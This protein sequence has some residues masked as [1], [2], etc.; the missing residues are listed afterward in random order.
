MIIIVSR[1][2][3]HCNRLF[4]SIHFHAY[5]IEAEH[6]FWNPTLIG[7]L[8]GASGYSE[9]LGDILQNYLLP[10]VLRL[11]KSWLPVY[12]DV[13]V[14]NESAITL[15]GGWGFRRHELTAKHRGFLSAFYKIRKPIPAF[16]RELFSLLAEAR[17][18]GKVIIGVHVR[19]GDYRQ[20]EGGRYW[21]ADDIYADWIKAARE[22]YR[23]HCNREIFVIVCSN[24]K[25][26]PACGQDLTSASP[27]HV[28]LRIFQAC[29]LL[30]GPPS[31]FTAWASYSASV[32]CIHIQ[33]Q[34]QQFCIEH[35]RIV[36]G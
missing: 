18:H 35:A 27:W 19:R 1:V 3:D 31:T 24:D 17:A 7:M 11:F 6:R 25:R 13:L 5:S 14:A 12:D 32:P 8:T 22:H 30:I 26:Q 36:D 9:K 15:V 2:G 34:S 23:V 21:F 4:Q 33:D 10:P 16:C 28:D 20:F 29:D